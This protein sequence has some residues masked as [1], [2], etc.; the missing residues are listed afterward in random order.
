MCWGPR[1]DR[2]TVLAGDQIAGQF[3]QFDNVY[4]RNLL[5]H[6]VFWSPPGSSKGATW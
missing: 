6:A 1:P 5:G 4:I 2:G 3:P